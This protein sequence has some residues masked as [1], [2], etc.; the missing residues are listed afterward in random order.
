MND[1]GEGKKLNKSGTN[2]NK[3][4]IVCKKS[5]RAGS[6]Y[7]SDECITKHAQDALVSTKLGSPSTKSEIIRSPFKA[8][9]SSDGSGGVDF[10]KQIQTS[11][12]VKNKEDRVIVFE[13]STNRC[14]TGANAPTAQN[15]KQWL[16]EHPTFQAVTPGTAQMNAI[17]AKKRQLKEV[18]SK[19]QAEKESPKASSS[20]FSKPT[21]IQTKLKF[22]ES[23]K[24]TIASPK[25]MSESKLPTLKS[26]PTPKTPTTPAH[27]SHSRHSSGSA[28]KSSQEKKVVK[29]QT[30]VDSQ[31]T[32]PG[33]KDSRDHDII[34]LKSKE[35]LQVRK[36]YFYCQQ[37]L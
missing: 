9:T 33:S 14:L 7:C 23:Q 6:I 5:A 20:S 30:S 10:D 29:R 13:K 35:G 16:K 19:L 25:E 31:K 11:K 18:A 1:S 27:P 26:P 36:I 4:C 32:T 21:K 8:H 2:G 28:G 22:S 17:M 12:I 3:L 34:R 15:L 37:R 24:L